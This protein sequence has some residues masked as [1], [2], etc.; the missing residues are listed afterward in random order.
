MKNLKSKPN[1]LTKQVTKLVEVISRSPGEDWEPRA[2]ALKDLTKLFEKQPASIQGDHKYWKSC[3][4]VLL[5]VVVSQVRG[6]HICAYPFIVPSSRLKIVSVVVRFS[7]RILA[8][9]WLATRATCWRHSR[10]RRAARPRAS[11]TSSC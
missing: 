1:E 5:L 6:R 11:S 7:W 2:Q 8:R 9:L 3:L 10:A 4:K